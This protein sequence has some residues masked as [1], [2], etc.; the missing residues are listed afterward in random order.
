MHSEE[1]LVRIECT[2]QEALPGLQFRVTE[3]GSGREFLAHL[4]GKM[5]LHRIRVIPGDRVLVEMTRY[6]DRRGRIVRR[7]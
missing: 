5:K 7:F 4:A 1:T 2:V 6:D 3:D